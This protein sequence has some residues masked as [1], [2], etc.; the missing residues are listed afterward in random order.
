MSSFNC[1]FSA[2]LG[3]TRRLEL[4][5]AVEAV[6]A[7]PHIV[8]RCGVNEHL[9]L[10]DWKCI[11]Y[12]ENLL[13]IRP[14]GVLQFSLAQCMQPIRRE[15]GVRFEEAHWRSENGESHSLMEF[16]GCLSNRLAFTLQCIM[17][18]CVIP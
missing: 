4:E 14:A 10:A 12:L 16:S 7:F 18:L 9:G 5:G 1:V 8:Q 11:T 13:R 15:A 2:A 6:K 17:Y 3:D